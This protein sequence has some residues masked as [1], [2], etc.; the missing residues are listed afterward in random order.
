MLKNDM[1]KLLF[2]QNS[3]CA[4]G[5]KQPGDSRSWESPD[6]ADNVWRLSYQ[7]F[8]GLKHYNLSNLE[9]SLEGN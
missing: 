9:T 4:R 6:E 3:L 5:C 7:T 8:Y 1:C 2:N